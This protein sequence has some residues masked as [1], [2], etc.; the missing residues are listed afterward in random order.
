[1]ANISYANHKSIM[2]APLF[3]QVHQ[4]QL[5]ENERE[6]VFAWL[7]LASIKP[8]RPPLQKEAQ[9]ENPPFASDPSLSERRGR[10][11]S[12]ATST[13][14]ARGSYSGF[15]HHGTCAGG[16]GREGDEKWERRGEGN[17]RVASELDHELV[18]HQL[19]A[20]ATR[21]A[22]RRG[23]LQDRVERECER[24]R[25]EKIRRWKGRGKSHA[26][27][28][29]LPPPH[30]ECAFTTTMPNGEEYIRKELHQYVGTE[31]QN[32]TLAAKHGAEEIG[33]WVSPRF[34]RS[35]FV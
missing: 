19:R 16:E 26:R 11:S 35:L 1:M 34:P 3:L 27:L 30:S 5:F 24:E 14:W 33:A 18:L 17:G 25:D 12:S 20:E 13:E 21:Y 8:V 10:N 2:F 28:R 6:K 4:Y 29:S 31:T 32:A 9:I 23:E 22:L 15:A 7:G